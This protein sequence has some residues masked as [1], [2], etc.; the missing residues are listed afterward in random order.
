MVRL[1]MILSTD[2][3]SSFCFILYWIVW[4]FFCWVNNGLLDLSQN[5]CNNNLVGE[6]NMHFLIRRR[7]NV[8]SNI[9]FIC[10]NIVWRRRC[11]KEETEWSTYVWSQILD[12]ASSPLH[13]IVFTLCCG[14]LLLFLKFK[15]KS[16]DL[17]VFKDLI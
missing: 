9:T 16:F 1:S 8:F 11:K 2:Q 15:N 6:S 7:C 13:V 4:F 10:F 12:M 3:N 5:S 14:W 17:H